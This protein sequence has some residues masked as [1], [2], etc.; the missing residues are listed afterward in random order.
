M[1][2][3]LVLQETKEFAQLSVCHYLSLSS[4]GIHIRLCGYTVDRFCPGSVWRWWRL[5]LRFYW[6]YSEIHTSVCSYLYCSI[7]NTWPNSL[8]SYMGETG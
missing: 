3:Q 4:L 2:I 6:S 1:Q 8:S 7:N 5:I